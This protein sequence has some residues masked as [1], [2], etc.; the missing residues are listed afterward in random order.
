[1]PLWEDV[2]LSPSSSWCL[3]QHGMKISS[4]LGLGHLSS[5][6]R[7]QSPIR[8]RSATRGKRDISSVRSLPTMIRRQGMCL[9]LPEHLQTFVLQSRAESRALIPPS[10]PTDKGRARIT[11]KA[12]VY[13][14]NFLL[15]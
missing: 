5:V 6:L 15:Q 2:C 14:F 4:L 13:I 11:P 12:D 8:S 3:N 1:M 9:Q 10:P 7:A